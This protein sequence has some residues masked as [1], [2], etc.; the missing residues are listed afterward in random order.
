MAVTVGAIAVMRMATARTSEL[1]RGS[2]LLREE[3]CT[4]DMTQ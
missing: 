4:E 2:C 1:H 3:V